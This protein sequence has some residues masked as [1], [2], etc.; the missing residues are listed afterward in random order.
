MAMVQNTPLAGT[1]SAAPPILTGGRVIATPLETQNVICLDQ[2]TGK[3]L[4]TKPRGGN[5]YLAGVF[6]GKVLL[7]GRDAVTAFDL[8]SGAQ[9]WTP[10]KTPAPSGRGVA[11]A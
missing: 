11:V 7:V 3:E 4:W 1:W 10:I 6:D 5:V 8:E 9:A 2:F